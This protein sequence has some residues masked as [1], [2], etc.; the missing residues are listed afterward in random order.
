MEDLPIRVDL[1]TLDHLSRCFKAEQLVVETK[2]PVVED[3]GTP[4]LVESLAEDEAQFPSEM[5]ETQ[6][7][8]LKKLGVWR[9]QFE[10]KYCTM[11]IR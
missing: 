10:C 1:Q 6:L 8:C 4:H 11:L 2:P 9:E 7:K 5:R 3:K